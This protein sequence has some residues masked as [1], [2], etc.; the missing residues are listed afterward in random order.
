MSPNNPNQHVPTDEEMQYQARWMIYDDD[1]PWNQ[2]AADNVEWLRRFKRDVGIL[3]EEGPGL[4]AI[5]AWA[6]EQGGTG[7]APP[8]VFPRGHLEA[9]GQL[10]SAPTQSD[11]RQPLAGPTANKSYLEALASFTS[12]QPAAIFCSRELEW[13]LEEFVRQFTA[14]NG[15]FPSDDALQR[16]AREILNTATT[17][18]D[19]AVLLNKFKEWVQQKGDGVATL[20]LP[21]AAG[22]E[23]GRMMAGP[24]GWL[25][26]MPLTSMPAGMDLNILDKDIGGILAGLDYNFALDEFGADMEGLEHDGG[27]SLA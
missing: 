18:A 21:S 26:K 11:G 23:V 10:G 5:D 1:D 15:Y 12:C 13:G 8:Y 16:R 7:F 20:A 19:D 3:K 24:E 25:E 27:V 2:T 9:L 22:P 17:A 6:T 14:Q 4:P